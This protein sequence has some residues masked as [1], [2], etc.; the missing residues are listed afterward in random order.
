MLKPRPK[1]VSILA[2]RSPLRVSG[3]FKHPSFRHDFKALGVRGA[4]ALTLAKIAQPAAFLATFGP[5]SGQDSD[6]GGR[7]AR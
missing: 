4:I 2:L 6:C 1:D 3:T 7:Y 5:G